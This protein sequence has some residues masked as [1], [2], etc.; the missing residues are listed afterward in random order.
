MP[1]A[2]GAI[3]T[4]QSHGSYCVGE[5]GGKVIR[6][7]VQQDLACVASEITRSENFTRSEIF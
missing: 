5:V 4:G 6:T 1:A 2:G 3:A 7:N